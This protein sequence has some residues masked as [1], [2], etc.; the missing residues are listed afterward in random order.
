MIHNLTDAVGRINSAHWLAA[1]GYWME[2][3]QIIYMRLPPPLDK[4]HRPLINIEAPLTARMNIE[5]GIQWGSQRQNRA[6]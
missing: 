1:I 2:I 5:Q 4:N 3:G 6:L